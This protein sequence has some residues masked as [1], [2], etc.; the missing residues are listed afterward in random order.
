MSKVPASG[1]INLRNLGIEDRYDVWRVSDL[2]VAHDPRANAA[3]LVKIDT[4]QNRGDQAFYFALSPPAAAQL[5]RHLRKAVKE[6]LNH[7]PDDDD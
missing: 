5:S 3:I 7:S 2:E 4:E 1:V 6:Y